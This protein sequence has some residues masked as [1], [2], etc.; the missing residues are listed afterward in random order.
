MTFE[1]TG[2]VSR[3][4]YTSNINCL[5]S[6]IFE[7]NMDAELVSCTSDIAEREASS[8]LWTALPCAGRSGFTASRGPL[9]AVEPREDDCLI[10]WLRLHRTPCRTQLLHG[11]VSLH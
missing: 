3:V 4:S 5:A 6:L 8:G 2:E 7:R 10:A 9:G 11:T 1:T